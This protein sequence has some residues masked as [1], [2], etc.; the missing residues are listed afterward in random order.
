MRLVALGLVLMLA[1]CGGPDTASATLERKRLCAESGWPFFARLKQRYSDP[2]VDI[3]GPLFAYNESLNTCLCA[4]Q[5]RAPEARTN[6]GGEF[7]SFI[8]ADIY[9]NHEVMAFHR[10]SQET[11]WREPNFETTYKRLMGT[12]PAPALLDAAVRY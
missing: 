6:V 11:T 8:V 4:Y 1:G 3:S 7:I 2:T 9:A 5:I 12:E 10:N